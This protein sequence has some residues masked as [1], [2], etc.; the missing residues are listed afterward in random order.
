MFKIFKKKE[1]NFGEYLVELGYSKTIKKINHAV[2]NN[3]IYEVNVFVSNGYNTVTIDFDS[4]NL[5][6]FR[7]IPN[8]KL[9]V[10]IIF[11][12]IQAEVNNNEE[13]Q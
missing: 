1:F 4:F 10:D 13:I 3:G 2:F 9:M 8:S 6:T 7:F 5:A 12:S 11:N